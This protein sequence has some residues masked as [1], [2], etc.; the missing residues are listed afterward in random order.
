MHR[1][2]SKKKRRRKKETF[3]KREERDG[4]GPIE[5]VG[6]DQAVKKRINKDRRNAG[7]TRNS[8]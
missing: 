5:G 4:S 2:L 7:E 6:G 8:L 1:L 3:T